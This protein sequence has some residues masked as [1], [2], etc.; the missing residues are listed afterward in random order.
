MSNR[1]GKKAV[2]SVQAPVQDAPREIV[3]EIEPELLDQKD[4]AEIAAAQMAVRASVNH[5]TGHATAL[6]GQMMR[7]NA[8]L[9]PSKIEAH[10]VKLIRDAEEGLKVVRKLPLAG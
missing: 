5:I 8:I 4:Q 1:K 9:Q 3:R 7:P 10:F 2:G 6:R